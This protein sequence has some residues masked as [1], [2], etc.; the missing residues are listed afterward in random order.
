MTAI[1]A[2]GAIVHRGSYHDVSV[3]QTIVS[4]GI[5]PGTSYEARARFVVDR[6]T[7]WTA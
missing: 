7:S 1:G 3:G 6:A 2:T 4:K 5:L